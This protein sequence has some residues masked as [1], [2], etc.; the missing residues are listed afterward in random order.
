MKS[1]LVLTMLQ[2]GSARVK[3]KLGGW[4]S[5]CDFAWFGIAAGELLTAE[6]AKK[7]R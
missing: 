1:K 3:S 5:R 7:G 4:W 6:I 2:N